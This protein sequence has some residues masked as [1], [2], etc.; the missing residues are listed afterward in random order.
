MKVSGPSFSLVAVSLN[1]MYPFVSVP[2]IVT[3]ATVVFV[4][5][6]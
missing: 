5:I 3:V 4:G 2:V 1:V 6:L